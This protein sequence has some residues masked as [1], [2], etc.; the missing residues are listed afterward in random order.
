MCNVNHVVQA[1]VPEQVEDSVDAA[2]Q[3]PEDLQMM[4]MDSANEDKL[5]VEQFLNENY[6]FRHNELSGKVEFIVIN[7]DMQNDSASE[8]PKFRALTEI[9][10]NSLLR[11]VEMA[12][13]DVGNPKHHVEMFVYSE[14]IPVFNPAKEIFHNLPDW[15]GSNHIANFFNRIPGLSAEQLYWLSVWFRSVGA[16]W[17]EMD[18]EHGNECVPTLIGAQGCGKSTFLRRI[19][20]PELREYFLD[21]VNLS[22]KN[23]K[24]MALTNN[25]I[26]NLDEMDQIKP[27]QHAELKQMLSKVRVN[28]RPIYGR[29][30]E[31][32]TRYASF[33]A[34]TNNP[35]PLN[36]P[37][38]SRRYICISIP[39]DKLIDNGTEIDYKQLYA[40]LLHELKVDKARYW[41]S[42]EETIAIQNANQQFQA[43]MD[44][45]SIIINC[46][47]FPKKDEVVKPLTVKDISKLILK[48]YPLMHTNNSF[49]IRLGMTLKS[50][51]FKLAPTGLNGHHG[52]RYLIVAN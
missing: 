40:Q 11:R 19:L 47:R 15:D 32:R 36:D 43:E 49:N 1:T 22:N 3:I 23:D 28:G 30:Q 48:Q 52:N 38:G 29:V 20:P 41:F 10:M 50:L 18:S 2:Q 9:A 24:N 25:L 31:D 51:G 13:P 6:K 39:A 4:E 37:T 27:A 33:V 26:V 46:F 5:L 7:P 45:S 21:H 44:I 17:L 35:H 34:T 42:N 8:E 12:L 16:H 14:D